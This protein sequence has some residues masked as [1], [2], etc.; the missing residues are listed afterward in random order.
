M[1]LKHT[2]IQILFQSTS[3]LTIIGASLN[4]NVFI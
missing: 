2:I 4:I 1:Y 3:A